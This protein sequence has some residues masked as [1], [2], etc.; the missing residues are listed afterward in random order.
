MPGGVTG[1]AHRPEPPSQAHARRSG[2]GAHRRPPSHL[3]RTPPTTP[4]P[5]L[6]RAAAS[7]AAAS[8]GA[9]LPSRP[10]TDSRARP[11]PTRPPVTHR[12]LRSALGRERGDGR[13]RRRD[14]RDGGRT[15]PGS[16]RAA[17]RRRGTH[18]GDADRRPG[19]RAAPGVVVVPVGLH[20]RSA[21][22]RTVARERC[23]RAGGVVTGV[24]GPRRERGRCPHPGNISFERKHRREFGSRRREQL[25]KRI[26]CRQRIRVHRQR[27]RVHRHRLRVHRQRLGERRRLRVF[28]PR[29]PRGWRDPPVRGTDLCRCETRMTSPRAAGRA[30]RGSGLLED[31]DR[32]RHHER[33]RHE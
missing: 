7:G 6:H 32:P 8:T 3:A 18:R 10:D 24:S 17:H 13:R 20:A 5:Q 25:R 19:P 23:R 29:P 27:I 21:R 30:S 16:G 26:A 31:V 33:H 11:D 22:R 28:G 9:R 1:R 15:Q 14:R 4:T 2:G 12:L